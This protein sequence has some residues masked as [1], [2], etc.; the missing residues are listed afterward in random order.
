M[1]VKLV[2]AEVLVLIEV[3]VLLELEEVL[4]EVLVVGT[5]AAGADVL[6]LLL[7]PVALEVVEESGGG[8]WPCGGELSHEEVVSLTVEVLDLDVL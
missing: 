1:L 4:V 6:E 5:T 2:V 7:V 8:T 3:E